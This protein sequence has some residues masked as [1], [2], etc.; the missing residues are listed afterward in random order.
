MTKFSD[1]YPQYFR[2]DHSDGSNFKLFHDNSCAYA[3]DGRL[4]LSPGQ[5]EADYQDELSVGASKEAKRRI[6]MKL[7]LDLLA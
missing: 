6:W 1:L 7:I 4:L 5:S 2:V 3:D